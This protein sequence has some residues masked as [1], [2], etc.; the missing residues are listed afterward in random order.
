MSKLGSEKLHFQVELFFPI[1]KIWIDSPEF[2]NAKI[3][4]ISK[5]KSVENNEIG[6]QKN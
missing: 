6:F 3:F 4:D 5:L 2:Q 1:S